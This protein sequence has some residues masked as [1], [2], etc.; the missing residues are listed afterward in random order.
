[1]GAGVGAVFFIQRAGANSSKVCVGAGVY[2]QG[3]GVY[4]RQNQKYGI[5]QV[6]VSYLPDLHLTLT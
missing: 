3:A 4:Y 5:A 6:Q 1:M 2:G